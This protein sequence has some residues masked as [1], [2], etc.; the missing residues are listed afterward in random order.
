MSVV[1]GACNTRAIPL[2]TCHSWSEHVLE[3]WC[4]GEWGC[5]VVR[6]FRAQL[7]LLP[8]IEESVSLLNG[9]DV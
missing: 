5:V 1:A 6:N 8:V 2:H 4:M 3:S 7:P 9:V